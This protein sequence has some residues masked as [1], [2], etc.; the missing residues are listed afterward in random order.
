MLINSIQF[1]L[2]FIVF[3]LVYTL[4]F[5][6]KTK[7]QNWLLL[8][9]SYY[10]YGVADWRMAILLAIITFLY[11]G[12]GLWLG[13]N[14]SRSILVLGVSLGVGILFYFKY[15]NFFI[16]SFVTL[17]N[18][19]GWHLDQI[20]LDIILPIGISFY[21]FKLM[22]YVIE[23]YR[24]TMNPCKNFV[25]FADYVAFFPTIMSGPIDRPNIFIPQIKQRGPF[26]ADLAIEGL[27]Q[28]AWG[29]FMKMCVAERIDL[30]VTSTF[31]TLDNQNGA[32]ITLCVFLYSIQ[33]YA[34]FAGYSDMAIGIGK[35]LGFHVTKNFDRPYFS[36]DVSEFWRKWHISLTRWLT[37]Y[38]YIPL[39]GSRCSILRVIINTLIVFTVCGL[40]HGAG[41][42]FI[43]WGFVNGLYFI[44]IL[45][46]KHRHDYKHTALTLKFPNVL[47]LLLTFV[48]IS[49]TWELF[50]S[51]SLASCMSV[52]AGM[53]KPWSLPSSIDELFYI[54]LCLMVLF[55]HDGRRAFDKIKFL[56]RVPVILKFVCYILL[57]MVV[58]RL[59]SDSFIYFQF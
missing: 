7:S 17:T 25:V 32:T 6:G 51:P 26:K 5:N 49:F 43:L 16:D 54:V 18:G 40:W 20:S 10:F 50:R 8:F 14:K 53:F 34:D 3:W 58:G 9:G 29:L 19:I 39:G 30:Y 35:L 28:M 36:R 21:L 2:F 12:I 27:V 41:W 42:T 47:R 31:D 55:I 13:K 1:F 45:L 33:I 22:S 11:Y 57:V 46:S 52:I 23:I 38:I 48:L 56:N 15:L 44:P 37:D 24:G 59:D 4:L